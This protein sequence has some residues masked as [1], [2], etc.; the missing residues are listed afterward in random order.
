VSTRSARD[1]GEALGA[2]GVIEDVFDRKTSA[3]DGSGR[4]SL[5]LLRQKSAIVAPRSDDLGE[6]GVPA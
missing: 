2:V 3:V 5:R 4:T 1:P 6:L